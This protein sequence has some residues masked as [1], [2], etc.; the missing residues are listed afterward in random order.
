[1]SGPLVFDLRV[2]A[3]LPNIGSVDGNYMAAGASFILEHNHSSATED[4]FVLD[5][6]ADGNAGTIRRVAI[7][8]N[9][10]RFRRDLTKATEAGAE[11]IGLLTV[12]HVLGRR[13]V[14]RMPTETG[15]DFLLE[16]IAPGS[17]DALERVEFGGIGDGAE[18]TTARLNRKLRQMRRYPDEPPGY[19][20]VTNFTTMPV[21]VAM[22]TVP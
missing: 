22:R 3:D 11:A 8:E 9:V 13:V 5:D 1:M 20:V 15:A 4:R 21:E 2:L 10:R 18:S 19:A 16:P 17:T 6:G 12:T 14:N 7:D